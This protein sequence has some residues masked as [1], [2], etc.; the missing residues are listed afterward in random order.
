MAIVVVVVAIAIIVAFAIVLDNDAFIVPPRN[1]CRVPSPSTSLSSSS[2]AIVVA[3]VTRR[4]CCRHRIPSRRHTSRHRH[5][6]SPAAVLSI[7]FAA[8]VDGWL[9]HSPSAQQHTS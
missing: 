7:T 6:P 8:P 2:A 3:I 9:L 5:Q 4:H 1:E